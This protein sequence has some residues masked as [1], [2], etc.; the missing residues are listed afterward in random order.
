TANTILALITAAAPGVESIFLAD[1]RHVIGELIG[2]CE[3][4][5]LARQ[6]AVGTATAGNLG[7]AAPHGCDRRLAVL[8]DVD[9]IFAG[10]SDVERQVWRVHFKSLVAADTMHPEIQRS[11][12]QAQLRHVISD[13]E[14]SDAG[15]RP[16]AYGSGSNLHLGAGIFIRP[17]IV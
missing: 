9:P 3:G 11:Y 2:T 14:Q 10:L 12:R 13:V 6:E 8:I 16:Q 17:E 7:L 5:L 4:S 15:L 1:S